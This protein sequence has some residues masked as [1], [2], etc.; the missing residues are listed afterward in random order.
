[1]LRHRF[2]SGEKSWNVC[3]IRFLSW[4]LN[5]HL[6]ELKIRYSSIVLVNEK[7]EVSLTRK[8][9]FHSVFEGNKIEVA[10]ENL[11]GGG[12]ESISFILKLY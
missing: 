7:W 1:M 8:K 11:G 2:M 4:G 3:L 12:G 5:C 9:G 6:Q 10:I